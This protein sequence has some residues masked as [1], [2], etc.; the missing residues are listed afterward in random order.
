M[1]HL[2]MH[3]LSV[4]GN[5]AICLQRKHPV[6]NLAHSRGQVSPSV[7]R[8]ASEVMKG[9]YNIFISLTVRFFP[10]DKQR[11]AC[12]SCRF[13]LCFFSPTQGKDLGIANIYPLLFCGLCGTSLNLIT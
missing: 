11:R 10:D 7:Y 3:L 5:V 1:R 4:K 12:V 6:F 13:Q 9:Q 8:V 2:Q